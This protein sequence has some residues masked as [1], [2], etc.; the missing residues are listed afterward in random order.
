MK[1]IEMMWLMFEATV[2]R[3]SGVTDPAVKAPI[4]HV[5]YAAA[6]TAFRLVAEMTP[7][8]LAATLGHVNQEAVV[9]SAEQPSKI[10]E[11]IPKGMVQ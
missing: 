3:A 11:L 10:D 4:R 9:W 2:L 5:Y 1:P 7:G 8:Q 6:I